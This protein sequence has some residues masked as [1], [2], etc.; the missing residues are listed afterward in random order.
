[1]YGS[2][3]SLRANS[4]GT[5]E[6]S[7]RLLRGSEVH[8]HLEVQCAE[9]VVELGRLSRRVVGVCLFVFTTAALAAAAH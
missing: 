5:I 4:Q 7:C 8:V 2:N 1:V 6:S 3:S 9:V